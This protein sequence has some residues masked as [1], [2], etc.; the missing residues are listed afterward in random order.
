MPPT[1]ASATAGA[2]PGW[3]VD[4][5]YQKLMTLLILVLMFYM[6][7]PATVFHP[8]VNNDILPPSMFL[9]TLKVTLLCAG[10]LIVVW[11]H[12]FALLLAREVNK[13]FIAYLALILT[14]VVWS[15]EPGITVTRFVA[16]LTVCLICGGCVM[17]GWHDKRFQQIVRTAF[18][19]LMIGS[20]I[21]GLI[22]PELAKEQGTGISLE[23]AWR[24][25][26]GQKN[27]LGH[28][29]SIA[30]FFWV[31]GWLAREVRFWKFAIGFGVSATCLLLSH[32]STAL[33]SA[34]F[35]VML[36]FLLLRA[37]K[38]KRHYMSFIV[39]IFVSLIL[40]YSLAVLDIFPGLDFLLQPIIDFTG[41]DN[42]FSGRTQIWAV[43]REHIRLAPI[44]GTGYGAYWIGP[45]PQS[46]SSVFLSKQSNF[47]P[48]EAH[49]GYLDI[50][51][52][53][54]FVGL[55]FLLGYLVVFLRQSLA[56]MKFNYTQ[57]AL[58][59]ALL[60]EELINNLTESD[61]LSSN[62][63]SFSVTTLATF[64]LARA[65]LEHRWQMQAQA[66]TLT[67]ARAASYQPRRPAQR[68][69]ATS[70]GNVR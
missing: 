54:G 16:V 28:A 50:I 63:F 1:P 14:S 4:T 57:A 67:E 27:G 3:L 66:Q 13:F 17:A 49:N 65:L 5:R 41:K 53:L 19:M 36:L 55:S 10:L 44:L 45:L 34:T 37:P 48:T 8:R 61:W 29:S 25:L 30:V 15:I 58:F 47:Y 42:T 60:F 20:L 46:P 68:W 43:I 2:D 51:N 38:Q 59:V 69:R 52:D 18:T 32:S 62:A 64:A 23:G 39:A 9:R 35:S 11:R 31:H 7:I 22:A 56:L 70:S 40:L 6:A 24:G 33:M 12:H 21:F 26:L